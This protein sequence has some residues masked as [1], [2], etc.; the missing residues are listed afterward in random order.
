M[1]LADGA[2]PDDPSE[3]SPLQLLQLGDAGL[4][5][6]GWI[7]QR[8]L[9]DE[10]VL[11]GR[12]GLTVQGA[13]AVLAQVALEADGAVRALQAGIGGQRGAVV[14]T[15]PGAVEGAPA[16]LGAVESHGDTSTAA[17]WFRKVL[18]VGYGRGRHR[19][20]EAPCRRSP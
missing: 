16:T 17:G 19:P 9:E 7:H 8:A 6:R 13:Q 5:V 14:G 15:G 20:R 4:E 11:I 1:Q 2:D 18:A 12:P 3:I 10:E